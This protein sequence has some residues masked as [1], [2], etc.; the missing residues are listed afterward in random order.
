MTLE[1]NDMQFHAYHGAL[2]QERIVGGQYRVSLRLHA[3]FQTA[4]C[5][6]N[7]ADTIDY[8]AIATAVKTEIDIPSNLIEHIVQRIGNRLLADFPQ[9][10]SID[11][12]LCKLHPPIPSIEIAEA[13]FTATFKRFTI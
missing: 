11:V 10:D 9:L 7:L 1:L 6:D 2:S 5:S 8:A 3:S 12:R 4:C 13:C